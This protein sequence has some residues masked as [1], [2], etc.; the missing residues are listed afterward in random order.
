VVKPHVQEEGWHSKRSVAAAYKQATP[1]PGQSP[2]L[3]QELSE[4]SQ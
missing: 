1:L 3:R 2:P 4:R